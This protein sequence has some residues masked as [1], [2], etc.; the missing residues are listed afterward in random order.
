M[1]LFGQNRAN[2]RASHR[3]HHCWVPGVPV[4]EARPRHP[5]RHEFLRGSFARGKQY[6]NNNNPTWKAVERASHY[7]WFVCF[8]FQLHEKRF[9]VVVVFR[10][11]C[12]QIWRR[13]TSELD[14][15]KEGT[16]PSR[17]F[18]SSLCLMMVRVIHYLY[19]QCYP[20][21]RDVYAMLLLQISLTPFPIWPVT[22]QRVRSTSTGSYT[23]DR[24][25]LPSTSCRRSLDSWSPPLARAWLE[26]T[27]QT[28]P[29][30]WLALAAF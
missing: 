11:T 16:A 22:S 18:P 19:M 4:R 25:I 9:Q 12:T 7:I 1:F 26:K 23:T 28:F 30:N 20:F 10:V 27:T 14:A 6:N 24:S 13:F 8:R 21:Y 29:T 3:A 17:R 5:H 15:W 2:R